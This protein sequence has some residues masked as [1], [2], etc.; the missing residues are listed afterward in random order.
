VLNRHDCGRGDIERDNR[1]AGKLGARWWV[2]SDH[3]SNQ[4]GLAAKRTLQARAQT[5]TSDG[6]DYVRPE[7]TRVIVADQA[8]VASVA[9]GRRVASTEI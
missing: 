5:G 8:A 6:L 3:L 9:D 2:L 4:L 1:V 7:L